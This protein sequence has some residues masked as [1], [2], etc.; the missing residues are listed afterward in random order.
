MGLRSSLPISQDSLKSG[1][2]KAEFDC[3][4]KNYNSD[5][6]AANVEIEERTN[7]ETTST[8]Q[9]DSYMYMDADS[10]MYMEARN[11]GTTPGEHHVY[12]N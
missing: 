7:G 10:Y 6:A 4:C 1:S 12:A 5:A 11:D 3:I 9:G 2:Q 8:R